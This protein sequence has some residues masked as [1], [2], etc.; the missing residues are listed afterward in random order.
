MQ[1]INPARLGESGSV[2][3][4]SSRYFFI[5]NEWFADTREGVVLGPYEMVEE[6]RETVSAFVSFMS[7]ALPEQQQRYLLWLQSGD[8]TAFEVVE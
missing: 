8:K 1:A 7:E 4:R 2:P 5:N 3:F 6:C